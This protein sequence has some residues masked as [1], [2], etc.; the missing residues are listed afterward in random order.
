MELKI[1]CHCGQKYKFD[2]EPVNGRMPV[3]VNCP[4][5]NADGTAAANA[6]LTE[7]L[8]GQPPPVAP[9]PGATASEAA[10]SAPVRSFRAAIMVPVKPPSKKSSF[11]LGLLGGIIGTA[12]GVA[13]YF[14]IFKFTGLHIKLLAIAVGALAGWLAEVFSKGE[15]SKELGGIT[16]VLVLAGIIGAQYF[17]ALDWWHAA[18]KTQAKLANAAYAFSVAE[19]ETAVKIIR[20]GSDAEIRTFLAKKSAEQGEE[21]SA[22][23]ISNKEVK[24]FRETRLPEYQALAEGQISK[25]QFL[26]EHNLKARRTAEEMTADNNTFKGFFLLLL[27]GKMNLFSLVAAAGLAFKL[28]SDA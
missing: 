15:G 12:V 19:A 5:C 28:S 26:E 8:A 21:I 7:L 27:L 17:V 23:T 11:A 10:P 18:A 22:A 3:P 6:R 16:A 14:S 24:E 13:V 2:V 25:E 1:V 9:A 20:T 4:V